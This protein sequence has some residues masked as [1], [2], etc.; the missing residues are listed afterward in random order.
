MVSKIKKTPKWGIR[1]EI[2]LPFTPTNDGIVVLVI[3]PQTSSTFSYFYV[4]S[5]NFK[6]VAQGASQAGSRYTLTFPVYAGETY[7]IFTATNAN[8]GYGYYCSLA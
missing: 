5:T 7:S 4:E 1:Q 2:T 6:G 8:I 3:W